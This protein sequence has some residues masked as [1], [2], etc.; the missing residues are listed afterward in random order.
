MTKVGD[1]VQSKYLKR[2]DVMAPKL[3]AIT[4]VDKVDVS[5]ENKPTEYKYAMSFAELDKPL[6]LN[7]TNIQTCMEVFGSTDDTNLNDWT[8]REIVIYD[9]PDVTYAGKKV[10]GLRLR[11]RKQKA[12]SEPEPEY[13]DDIPF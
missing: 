5:M 9:D 2:S 10:G 3:V 4:H 12:K 6:I 11:A 13:D 7:V 8:G 1:L